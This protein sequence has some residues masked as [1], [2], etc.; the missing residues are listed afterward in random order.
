LAEEVAED[1]PVVVVPVVGSEVLAGVDLEVAV[2]EEAGK[3]F[4]GY[5]MTWK[6]LKTNHPGAVS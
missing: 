1:G 3:T 4:N 2:L 6:L 5:S